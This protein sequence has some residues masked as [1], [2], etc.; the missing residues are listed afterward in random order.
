MSQAC[1]CLVVFRNW[2]NKQGICLLTTLKSHIEQI[3]VTFRALM[4]Y[5]ARELES[6]DYLSVD[7]KGV[8]EFVHILESMYSQQSFTESKKNLSHNDQKCRF[9]TNAHL[10]HRNTMRCKQLNLQ[11]ALCRIEPRL[12]QW[13]LLHTILLKESM[14]FHS[15]LIAQMCIGSNFSIFFLSHFNAP[16]VLFIWDN[17]V[18]RASFLYSWFIRRIWSLT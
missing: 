7:E 15:E 9:V 13:C 2:H 1:F 14:K 16:V 10:W 17:F 6:R 4:S 12:P 3:L 5:Q 11:I 8:V 18:S